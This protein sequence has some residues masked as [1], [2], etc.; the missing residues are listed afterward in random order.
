MTHLALLLENRCHVLRKR[1]LLASGL[2]ESSL[3][4]KHQQTRRRHHPES[5]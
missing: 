3:T 5:T 1:D 2:R 4:G